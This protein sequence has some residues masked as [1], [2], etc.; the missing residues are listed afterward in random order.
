[1]APST[2]QIA[3][4][5]GTASV[6]SHSRLFRNREGISH[7]P[8][9]VM[10]GLMESSDAAPAQ[11]HGSPGNARLYH[12][13]GAFATRSPLKTWRFDLV[14]GPERGVGYNLQPGSGG[15]GRARRFDGKASGSAGGG[16]TPGPSAAKPG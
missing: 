9:I 15:V 4:Q 14:I 7:G 6:A 10:A 5:L 3:C 16:A 11:S 1:M 2:P 13:G 8:S 12:P